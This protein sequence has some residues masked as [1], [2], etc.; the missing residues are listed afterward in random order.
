MKEEEEGVPFGHDAKKWR[1]RKYIR[2][3]LLRRGGDI[4]P[5]LLLVFSNCLP[6]KD[7]LFWNSWHFVVKGKSKSSLITCIIDNR[8]LYIKMTILI[9]CNH[10]NEERDRMCDD[11]PF[12]PRSWLDSL[13]VG[14]PSRDHQKGANFELLRAM[15]GNSLCSVETLNP[16][17]LHHHVFAYTRVCMN[18]HLL[19]FL[20]FPHCECGTP[21]F[22]SL[23]YQMY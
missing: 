3:L 21:S 7:F 19:I 15:R 16:I 17:W 6:F 18:T 13:I 2:N 23:E 8:E 20:T 10:D 9:N 22:Q 12:F 4:L 14:F 1:K 11:L 5:H